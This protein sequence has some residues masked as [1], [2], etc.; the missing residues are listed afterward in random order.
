[1]ALYLHRIGQD[2]SVDKGLSLKEDILGLFEALQF[3]V[4]PDFVQVLDELSSDRLI[5]A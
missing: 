3:G 1:M 4:L 2:S 5:P